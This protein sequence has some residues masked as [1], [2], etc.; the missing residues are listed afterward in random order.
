MRYAAVI[1]D[2]E[3]CGPGPD[4]WWDSPKIKEI[5]PL[6]TLQ[7]LIEWQKNLYPQHRKLQ[8]DGEIVCMTIT[9]MA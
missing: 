7:D 2:A 4:D 9:I 1:N 6:T 3:Q 5:H 8:K